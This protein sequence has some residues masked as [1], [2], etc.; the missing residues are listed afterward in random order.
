EACIGEQ[1]RTCRLRHE[2]AEDE[3]TTLDAVAA[4]V[5]VRVADQNAVDCTGFVLTDGEAGA[6]DTAV[7]VALAAITCTQ[8]PEEGDCLRVAQPFGDC[9]RSELLAVGQTELGVEVTD[10]THRDGD[11][12]GTRKGRAND[13]GRDADG[14]NRNRS[15]EVDLPRCDACAS[16]LELCHRLLFLESNYSEIDA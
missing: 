1:G 9:Q 13:A 5:G 8:D 6:V 11:E 15:R 14:F 16:K 7:L 12:G 3:G 10:Q 4:R 2:G